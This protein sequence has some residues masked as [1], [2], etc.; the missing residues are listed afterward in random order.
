METCRSMLKIIL[1]EYN[2]HETKFNHNCKVALKHALFKKMKHNPYNPIVALS[3]A[4]DGYGYHW[5]GH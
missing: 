4:C 3:L 2:S 1:K 5:K